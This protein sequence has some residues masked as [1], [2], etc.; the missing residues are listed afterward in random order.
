MDQRCFTTHQNEECTIS[1]SS[2]SSNISGRDSLSVFEFSIFLSVSF[3]SFSEDIFKDNGT[4]GS[5]T[6]FRIGEL[7]FVIWLVWFWSE[8]NVS[9]TL[10]PVVDVLSFVSLLADKLF[11]A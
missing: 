5:T 9:F 7:T 8:D 1:R 6:N 11:P 2:P 4:K 10:L 3:V